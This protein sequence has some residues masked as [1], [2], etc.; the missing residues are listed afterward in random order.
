MWG[1]TASLTLNFICTNFF[2][3]RRQT[4]CSCLT[5]F[6]ARAAWTSRCYSGDIVYGPYIIREVL[7]YSFFLGIMFLRSGPVKRNVSMLQQACCSLKHVSKDPLTL[8]ARRLA[9][10]DSLS[11][12]HQLFDYGSQ[13]R[14]QIGMNT[15]LQKLKDMNLKQVEAS[16]RSLQATERTTATW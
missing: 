3:R 11:L 2:W 6:A 10:F 14:C 1:F 5:C 4:G 7:Q 16:V 15:L 9:W 12:Q 13:K 8:V